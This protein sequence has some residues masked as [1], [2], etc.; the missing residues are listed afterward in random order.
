MKLKQI[1]LALG[2]A[3]LSATAFSANATYFGDEND[4]S[5][6][7]AQHTLYEARTTN[8]TPSKSTI[9]HYNDE[10]DLSWLHSASAK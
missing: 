3:A 9:I 6:L 7:P 4:L 8:T 10:T 2:A 5:W 1:A